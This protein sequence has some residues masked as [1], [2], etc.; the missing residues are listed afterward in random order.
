MTE[1]RSMLWYSNA[2]HIPTG[3]GTQSAM[4]INQLT[5]DNYKMAIA[6][7]YGLEGV[8]SNYRINNVNVPMFSRGYDVWSN[9]IIGAHAYTWKQQNPDTKFAITTLFDVWV[10]QKQHWGQFPVI[11]WIPI[12]HSPVPSPVSDWAQ[13]DFVHPIAMS[14]FGQKQLQNL[15]IKAYYIPHAIDKVFQPTEKLL[16]NN[17]TEVSIREYLNISPETFVIGINAANKGAIPSR[18]AWSENLLAFSIFAKNKKDVL[19]YLHTDILGGL[20]GHGVNLLDVIKSLNIPEEKIKW[21]DQYAYKSGI[22]QEVVAGIYTSMDVLLA[23]S[24]GEGFGLATLEAQRCQTPV[25]VT[26]CAASSELVG[27]GYLV[28]GQ[29]FWN[30]PMKAWFT[31]P[32]VSSIV[33]ALEQ[34]YKRGRKRSTKAKAFADKFDADLIYETMWKPTLDDIYSKI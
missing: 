33:D 32:Y 27:D 17:G 29:L 18:K 31:V 2:P 23:T 11:S 7:N 8:N 16:T 12:D 20:P 9:D 28:E 1:S 14:K 19:L 24:Y 13:L 5:K 30:P 34:A 4:M 25:I 3:Y 22:S 21:V 26:D 6:A 10:F 15:N